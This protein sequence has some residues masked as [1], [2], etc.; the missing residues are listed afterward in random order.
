MPGLAD[1][2]V[3]L[4]IDNIFPFLSAHDIVNLGTANKFLYSLIQD[5]AFWHRRIQEDFNFPSA[6]TARQT[7]W[8]FL[9]KRLSNLQV[10]VWGYVCE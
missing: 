1:L 4:F 5:E 3:E 6:D 9:Y 2:P 10:Y 8:L 7:G